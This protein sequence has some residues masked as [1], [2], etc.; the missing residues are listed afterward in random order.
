MTG[1]AGPMGAAGIGGASCGLLNS[2]PDGICNILDQKCV[3]CLVD[4]DCM[5]GKGKLCNLSTLT[6][7][8]CRTDADCDGD[9]TCGADGSCSN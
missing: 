5:K 7:V 3:D 1:A 9:K 6:C 2:C 4:G 8:E